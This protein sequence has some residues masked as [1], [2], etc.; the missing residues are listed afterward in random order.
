MS[1]IKP[2]LLVA[3]LALVCAI[4]VSAQ[5]LA[6]A[7]PLP[8][9]HWKTVGCP[10]GHPSTVS[11]RY[12]TRTLKNQ[13][14]YTRGEGKKV[15]H[16]V[17]CVYTK[18]KAK[19][20]ATRVENLRKWRKQNVCTA[21]R[22]NVALGE[23][24]A[25]RDGWTG[26]EWSCLYALWSRESGWNHLRANYAGSGAYGIPQ[27][28]PGSKMGP[29]WQTNPWVQIKWG[30]GYIRGRYGTPCGANGFQASNGWY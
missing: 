27:A 15:R 16:F 8:Q 26:G 7:P 6:Q 22:V 30:L 19:R 29:G 21:A 9:A 28:L 3:A 25:R 12:V 23:C 2:L 1:I 13:T 24:L 5:T 18:T 14:P 10:H 11:L 20:L 4:P 17:S